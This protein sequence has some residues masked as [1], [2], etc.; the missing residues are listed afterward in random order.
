MSAKLIKIIVKIHS[1]RI[2]P[3]LIGLCIY[4]IQSTGSKKHRRTPFG[5]V[6]LLKSMFSRIISSST[7]QRP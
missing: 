5:S 1:T 3:S 6:R 2:F 7:L 4:L